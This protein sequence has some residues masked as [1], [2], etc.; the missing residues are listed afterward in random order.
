MLL[1]IQQPEYFPWLGFLDKLHQADTTVWLDHVQFKKRYFENRNKVRDHTGWRWLRTP[2]LTKGRDGQPINQVEIDNSAPW[3]RKLVATLRHAYGRA[4][5]WSPGGEELCEL[6]L[7]R[8]WTKLVDFNLAVIELLR[9]WFGLTGVTRRS[10]ELGVTA[11]G[12]DLILEI[13][14]L[15]GA[16]AYLVGSLGGNYLREEDF[17]A[18]GIRLVPQDFQHPV[19]P[20]LHPGPFLPGLSAVDLWLNLGPGAREVL[21]GGRA[22]ANP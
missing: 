4:P 1:S 15:T 2:V 9:R 13:A 5:Y 14:T 3:T 19:Y 12:S 10:S 8:P 16:D 22:D 20:Q 18:R 21:A 17:R 7:S 11:Q 6:V